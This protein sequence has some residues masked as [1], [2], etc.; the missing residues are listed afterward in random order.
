M[1][2]WQKIGIVVVLLGLFVG[3]QVGDAIARPFRPG[4]IPNGFVNACANCHVNPAGGGPRN[5][6]GQLVEGE[7][8]TASGIS[9][10]VIWN[11]ALASQDSDGDGFTNGEELGDPAGAW[12]AGDPAPTTA[13]RTIPSDLL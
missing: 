3:L 5:A 7:F 1:L 12:R 11:A 8:L 9:G 2:S 6:F 4:Q 13:S 10:N